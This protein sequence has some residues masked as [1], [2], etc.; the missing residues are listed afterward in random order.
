MPEVGE[1]R[2]GREIGLFWRSKYIWAACIDC[3]KCRWVYLTKGKPAHLRCKP[4]S[5]KTRRG[6]HHPMWQGGKIIDDDGYVKIL[7]SPNDFFYPMA[8]SYGYVLEHRLVM[9]KHLGRCLQP[10]EIVHHKGIR[11]RGIKNRSDNLRDNL[12]LTIRGSHSREHSKGYRD[13]YQRG[14]VDGRNKQIQELK[15]LIEEQT[16]QIRLLQWQLKELRNAG[17]FHI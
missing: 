11:Y 15:T 2:R 6:S 10:W 3:G 1:I 8:N 13:G 12:E 16:K 17:T 5:L 14:L 9:A 7:L 4:C